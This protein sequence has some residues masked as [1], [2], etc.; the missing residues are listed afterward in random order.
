MPRNLNFVF[1]PF[2]FVLWFHKGEK[3]KSCA[4]RDITRCQGMLS[5]MSRTENN[6][7]AIF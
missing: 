4:T 5:V 3:K 2:H 7:I 6:E 1:C